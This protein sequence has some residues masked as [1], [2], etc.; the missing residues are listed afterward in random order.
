[1]Q[2]A[3]TLD[4]CDVIAHNIATSAR[5]V[6]HRAALDE[7]PELDAHWLV[8]DVARHAVQLAA[9]RLR[10][11]AATTVPVRPTWRTA[12]DGGKAGL[13]P[14]GLPGAAQVQ[15][16]RLRTAL[17]RR[18]RDGHAELHR[19]RSQVCCWRTDRA[20]A[21]A[22]AN[23]TMT[24]WRF[25]AVATRARRPPCKRYSGRPSCT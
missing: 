16:E 21:D 22:L 14:A 5:F 4:H 9:V 23:R 1:M 24:A 15:Y 25:W 3:T 18:V 8:L 10:G 6:W 20:G 11:S 13:P 19:L 12:V 2:V 7:L 17:S